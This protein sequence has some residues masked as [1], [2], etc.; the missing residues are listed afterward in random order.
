MKIVLIRH[1][2]SQ[3]NVDHN[4]YLTTNDANVNLTDLGEDQAT[5]VGITLKNLLKKD[6]THIFVSPY[7]RTKQTWEKISN[8]LD[9]EF[10]PV[11]TPIIREQEYKVFKDE[12]EMNLKKNER[13]EFGPFWY[14]F[15]NGESVADVY[16]RVLS[17]INHLKLET[18]LN[19]IKQSDTVVIVS[20]EVTIRMFLMI[21][22]NLQYEESKQDINNC[23]PIVFE[24][25]KDFSIK[26]EYYL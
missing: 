1:G 23:E 14:R 18:I 3:G 25:K 24:L 12:T 10:K 9:N 17:F 8:Q 6:K 21:F 11:F 13:N 7:K 4:I 15:K 26:K 20:H 19:N 16:A 2:Q 22:K 5:K